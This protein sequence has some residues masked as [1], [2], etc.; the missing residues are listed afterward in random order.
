MDPQTDWVRCQGRYALDF[1][2][3]NDKV[4]TL[5]PVLSGTGDFEIAAWVYPTSFAKYSPLGGN[6]GAGNLTGVQMVLNIT[7]GALGVFVASGATFF[8]S[9]LLS[10]N[11]WAFVSVCRKNGVAEVFVNGLS[12]GTAARSASIGT[13]RN[14]SIGQ[15]PD[16]T[17]EEFAGLIAEQRVYSRALSAGERARLR[18]RSGIAFD[19]AP[20]KR[21]RVFTGGFKAAW[22]ARKAQILG[23][24]L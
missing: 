12:G 4:Q 5:L 14:W 13:S 2:G 11:T 1:D 15:G 19:L 6:Y 23:G 9:I 24:G 10:L 20:R 16:Y 17:G 3:S 18:S 7:T 22:A 8:G 21:S